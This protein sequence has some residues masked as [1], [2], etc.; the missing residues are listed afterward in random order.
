MQV[1]VQEIDNKLYVSEVT[2]EPGYTFKK[3]YEVEF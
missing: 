2:R 1:K 3:N